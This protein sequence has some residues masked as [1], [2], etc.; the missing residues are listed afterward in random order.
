MTK[1][2]SKPADRVIDLRRRLDDANY[3]YHVLDEPDI[4][5]IEYERF[6]NWRT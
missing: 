5:D 2:T 4:P 6:R 1:T 3:R